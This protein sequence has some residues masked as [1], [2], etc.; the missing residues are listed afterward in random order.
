MEQEKADLQGDINAKDATIAS[1]QGE[2]ETRQAELDGAKASL[3]TAQKTIEERDATLAERDQQITDLNAQLTELQ[4]N[5]G[6]QPAAG[7]APQNN[8]GGADAP[9]LVVNQYVYDPALSYK[10]NRELEAKWNAE[11]GKA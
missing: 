8:G 11:H 9:Q 4:N 7:A 3:E 1:L 2:A 10:E 5:P 6:Q